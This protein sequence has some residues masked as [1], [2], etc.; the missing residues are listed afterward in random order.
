M[1]DV[2]KY[3]LPKMKINFKTDRLLLKPISVNDS[4][5]TIELVNTEEWKTFI[6]K[7]NIHTREEASE[8][9]QKNTDD[10][11]SFIWT[12]FLKKTE[13]PIGIITLLKRDYL[14]YHDIGFAF[15]PA[16][17]HKGYAFESSDA[18]LNYIKINKLYEHVQAITSKD[19]F[20]SVKLLKKLG[21]RFEKEITIE[22]SKSNVYII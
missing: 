17:F 2:R 15:L 7:R 9:I 18:V 19:N 11:N 20:S 13:I 1:Y 22:N 10:L 5:F 14:E 4:D 6:G 16:Y 8:F 12:V 3:N 21:F